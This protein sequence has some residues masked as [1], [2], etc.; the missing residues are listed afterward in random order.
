MLP[1]KR[2]NLNFNNVIKILIV[3]D[4]VVWSSANMFN[5]IFSVF[6]IDNIENGSL[7]SAGFSSTIYLIVSAIATVPM[8]IF[9]D[10]VKGHLD[11]VYFLFGGTIIRGVFIFLFAFIDQLWQL[12]AIQFILGI[13]R[14]A[15]FPSWRILF[16]KYTDRKQSGMEWSFYDSITTIGMGLSAY[17][18]SFMAE[19]IGFEFL[20]K[21]AGILTLIGGILII[22]LKGILKHKK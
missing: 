4:F 9:M 10:K 7:E 16:S 1:H 18:G 3:S 17:L 21:T 19:E 11:E 12:Y 20:F 22:V 13:A 6:V 2:L 8:G 5:V 14:A 15:M